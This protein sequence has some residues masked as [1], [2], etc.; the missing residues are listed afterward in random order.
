MQ[1]L[2]ENNIIFKSQNGFRNNLGTED[3]LAQLSIKIYSNLNNNIKT[4][5]TFLDFS[6]AF[7][8]ISHIFLLNILKFIGIINKTFK[9]FESYLHNRTQQVRI[10]YTLSNIT[11]IT[12]GI[13]QGTVLL[14]I[15]YIIYDAS[16]DNLNIYGNLFL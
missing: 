14:P 2:E 8:N 9:L 7:D 12:S 1:Y 4:L 6:K 11:S 13:P 5:D 3:T 16:S 10:N 15:L